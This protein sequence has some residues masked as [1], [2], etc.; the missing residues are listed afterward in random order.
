[1]Y[2]QLQEQILFEIRESRLSL[3]T[4]NQR[5]QVAY[6]AE[7][8]AR[9]NLETATSLWRNGMS[10]HL[11]MLDAYAKLTQAEFETISAK[12]DYLLAQASLSHAIGTL[13]RGKY[14]MQPPPNSSAPNP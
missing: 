13:S 7:H 1:M 6:R 5:L 11:E 10:R 8:S 12:A 4:A 9:R 2:D 14:F 3:T